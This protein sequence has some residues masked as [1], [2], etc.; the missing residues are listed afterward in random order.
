MMLKTEND[1]RKTMICHEMTNAPATAEASAQ[2]LQFVYCWGTEC[3][4]WRWFD[5]VCERISPDDR[6]GYCGPV[7]KPEVL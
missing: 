5:P 7:G 1:A 3:M 4:G 2:G 6:R